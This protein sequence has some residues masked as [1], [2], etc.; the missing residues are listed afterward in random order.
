MTPFFSSFPKSLV[1]IGTRSWLS[2][3]PLPTHSDFRR[4][5]QIIII[6]GRGFVSYLYRYSTCTLLYSSLPPLQPDQTTYIQGTLHVSQWFYASHH[7]IHRL[8]HRYCTWQMWCSYWC[9]LVACVAC[10][11]QRL[12]VHT[13]VRVFILPI[14]IHTVLYVMIFLFFLAWTKYSTTKPHEHI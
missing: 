3:C 7:V 8:S 12:E 9:N 1:C 14:Y 5:L 13:A 2:L 11:V 10:G 6:T 4:A